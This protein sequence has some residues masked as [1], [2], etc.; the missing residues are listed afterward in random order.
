M[1]N[2]YVSNI[3]LW[4][5]CTDPVEVEPSYTRQQSQLNSHNHIIINGSLTRDVIQFHNEGSGYNC[6]PTVDKELMLTKAL[7]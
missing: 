5:G 6:L 4:Q 2:S 7:M 1:N 3:A